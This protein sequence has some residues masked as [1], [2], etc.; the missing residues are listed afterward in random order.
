[1]P[2]RQEDKEFIQSLSFLGGL[3]GA[4]LGV[5][6]VIHLSEQARARNAEKSEFHQT[7]AALVKLSNAAVNPSNPI[8]N[9]DVLE[10]VQEQIAQDPSAGKSHEPCF[11]LSISRWTFRGICAGSGTVGAIAG[12]ATIRLTGW[13]GSLMLF[14]LIRLL[15]A[16][17]RK[18]APNS[19]AAQRPVPVENGTA[20]YQ[21]DE[22][23]L[24]PVMVKLIFLLLLALSV[25]AAVVWYLTAL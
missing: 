6:V 1:M 25:L 2:I 3:L 15:Y 14:G 11:W 22:H 23:R 7:Q 9:S 4:C 8:S 19:A 13:V 20:L 12:Y 5:F 17:I 24:L 16:G 18:F 10:R 21:R